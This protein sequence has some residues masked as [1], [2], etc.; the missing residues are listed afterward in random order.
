MLRAVIRRH[1]GDFP[2]QLALLETVANY[3]VRKPEGM[4]KQDNS[5]AIRTS[6]ADKLSAT[7]TEPSPVKLKKR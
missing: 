6:D 5:D 3:I 4:Q 1:P 2:R 7:K